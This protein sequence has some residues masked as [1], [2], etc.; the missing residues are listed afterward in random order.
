MR[1]KKGGES[2]VDNMLKEFEGKREERDGTVVG[3]SVGIKDRFFKNMGD[4]GMLESRG[5]ST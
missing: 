3:E 2:V 4:D 5:D 1:G